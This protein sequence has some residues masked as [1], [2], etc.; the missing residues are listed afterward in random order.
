MAGFVVF[1]CG[2]LTSSFFVAFS[3]NLHIIIGHSL[4]CNGLQFSFKM[5]T[6]NNGKPLKTKFEKIEKQNLDFC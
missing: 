1:K 4:L 3:L 2:I 5:A 6:D